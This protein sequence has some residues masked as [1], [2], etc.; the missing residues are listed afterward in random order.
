MPGF[1]PFYGGNGMFIL[2]LM[3]YDE[4]GYS[5]CVYSFSNVAFLS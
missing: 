5:D 3:A 1:S 2:C 4:L